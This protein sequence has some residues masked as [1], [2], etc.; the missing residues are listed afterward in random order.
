MVMRKFAPITSQPLLLPHPVPLPLLSRYH[1]SRMFISGLPL[2]D[3]LQSGQGY[4]MLSSILILFCFPDSFCHAFS[5]Q[6]SLL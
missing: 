5:K 2:Y 4:K 6:G 3:L 1:G